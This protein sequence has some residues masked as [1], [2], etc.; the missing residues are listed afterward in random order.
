M[1]NLPVR[2]DFFLILPKLNCLPTNGEIV[3][4]VSQS[5]SSE[6]RV[7]TNIQ[8]YIYRNNAEYRNISAYSL[9]ELSKLRDDIR[10][11]K[12]MTNN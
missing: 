1:K 11:S 9:I 5:R 4:Q 2:Q 8:V 12:S 10:K 7:A 3:L 6:T